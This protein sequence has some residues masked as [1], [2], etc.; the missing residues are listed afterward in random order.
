M[1][2]SKCIS[3]AA[4]IL[5][6]SLATV[7]AQDDCVPICPGTVGKIKVADPY[8]CKNYY[9]CRNSQPDPL[10]VYCGDGK[11]FNSTKGECV[12]E[13]LA[14]CEPRCYVGGGTGICHLTCEAINDF[15]SDPFDCSTYY[16]C[17]PG[18]KI[19]HKCPL[20]KPYFSITGCSTDDSLCC[21][22]GCTPVC[23]VNEVIIADPTNCSNYYEC[24]APGIPSNISKRSCPVGTYFDIVIG[25]CSSMAECL[26]LCPDSPTVIPTNDTT[27][28]SQTPAQTTFLPT[29]TDS[30]ETTTMDCVETF[31]CP[32]P[33]YYPKCHT[34]QPEYY[35]CESKGEEGSLGR[36]VGELV[37]NTHPDL[38]YC[39]LPGDCPLYP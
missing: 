37:F 5:T 16:E 10:P 19:P 39:V 26:I 33:G 30:V 8:N 25:R 35:K 20:S 13:T 3:V 9:F 22:P 2:F 31:S 38:P 12:T 18:G 23:N 17:A 28:D 4:V 34:C 1:K 11:Q 6:F 36:C 15:V 21:V 32:G 27:V 7:S 29:Q 24:Q 14:S